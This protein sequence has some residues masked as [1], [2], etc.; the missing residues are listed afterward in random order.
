MKTLPYV[1]K[2][3]RAALLLGFIGLTACGGG[4]SSTPVTDPG[5][6]PAQLETGAAQGTDP[7]GQPQNST[8]AAQQV[9]AN[10]TPALDV[11]VSTIN[12]S[13]NSSV[14][15]SSAVT[16]TA[17]INQAI[18]DGAS[19][20]SCDAPEAAFRDTMLELINASRIQAR[21]CGTLEHP[22]VPTVEWN[23]NLAAAAQFHANDMVVNNFFAHTGSD[24]L[25][26]VE[27]VEMTGYPWR[28][29]GENIAAGQLDVAEVHQAWLDSEGHCVNIMNNAFSEVGAA[30]LS[31]P[32]TDF[33]NY[34]VVVFGDSQ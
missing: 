7:V 12:S 8:P 6:V 22:A 25:G 26:A 31:D 10:V 17:V 9:P 1:V 27:R 4:T 20:V 28:A 15:D 14:D 16:V 2:I 24:G 23:T 29:V 30:C 11:G 21:M 19:N 3:N 5:S 13:E 32:G 33:G 18:I 34:W